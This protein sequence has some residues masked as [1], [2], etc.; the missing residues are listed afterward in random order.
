M[1]PGRSLLIV[2]LLATI[3]AIAFVTGCAGSPG[4]VKNTT[5]VQGLAFSNP[6]P[7]GTTVEFSGEVITLTKNNT[8]A[9]NG[10]YTARLT[11]LDTERGDDA[12]K[13]A[14]Q[15]NP[16]LTTMA[17]LTAQTVFDDILA[18]RFRFELINTSNGTDHTVVGTSM[19]QLIMPEIGRAH[20]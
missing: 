18:V 9:Q 19:W 13:L 14:H 11:L 7:V 16:N 8:S 20:V 15:I 5:Y 4:G 12:V 10:T 2:I 3:I 1:N 17:D 6:A